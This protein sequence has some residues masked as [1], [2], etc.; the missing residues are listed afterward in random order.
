[1]RARLIANPKSGTDRA[2]ELLPLINERLRTIVDD[3]DITLTTSIQDAE[4]AAARAVDE[5]YDAL[6]VA[7]GDGTL[8]GVLRG[9]VARD[10]GRHIPIGVIP[11]GTGNDFVKALGLGEDPEITPIG[12]CRPPSRATSPR[13]TPFNVP[14][15]PAT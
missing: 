8:N 6:Y 13:R 11:A 1:M 2:P 4:R 5:A 9:L 12:M 15:P 10:G 7:G 3:L 14:S